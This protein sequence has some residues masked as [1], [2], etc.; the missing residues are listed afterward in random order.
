MPFYTLYQLYERFFS[1][2][3]NYEETDIE[4]PKTFQEAVCDFYESTPVQLSVAVLIALNFV[5]AVIDAQSGAPWAGSVEHTLTVIFAVELCINFVGNAFAP[6]FRSGW[7]WFDMLVVGVS[8]GQIFFPD[9][10]GIA[11]LRLFRAFRAARIFRRLEAQRRIVH[12]VVSSLVG[13]SNVLM[14]IFLVIGIWS[15]LSVNFFGSQFPDEFGSVPK[16]MRT[17]LQIVT[18]DGWMSKIVKPIVFSRA[19]AGEQI[20]AAFLFISFMVIMMLMNS[21]IAVLFDTYVQS[22]S[23]FVSEKQLRQDAR[24]AK[25]EA[26]RA[27]VVPVVDHIAM[28][29]SVPNSPLASSA[30][31]RLV[32]P[33]TDI[34]VDTQDTQW[35]QSCEDQ[36]LRRLNRAEAMLYPELPRSHQWLHELKVEAVLSGSESLRR[37]RELA[38]GKL[39]KQVHVKHL[40]NNKI[41]QYLVALLITANFV[42]SAYTA[43]VVDKAD[44][45]RWERISFNETHPQ[46]ETALLKV[47]EFEDQQTV[48]DSIEVWFTVVFGI[49]LVINLYGNFLLP[50]CSS[51]W[52]WFDFLVVATSI[53]A[54]AVPDMP[55]ITVLRLFRAFRVFR[56]FKRLE[57]LRKVILGVVAAM[58]DVLAAF[59]MII[60]LTGIWS[61]LAVDLLGEQFPAEFGDFFKSVLTWFQVMT[62]DAW[63]SSILRRILDER[64]D[65]WW[66]SVLF[67]T[68]MFLTSIMLLNTMVVVLID[69]YLLATNPS[70]ILVDDAKEAVLAV[71]ESIMKRMDVVEDYMKKKHFPLYE[72]LKQ[73]PHLTVQHRYDCQQAILEG[74][75]TDVKR[76]IHFLQSGELMPREMWIARM[77][78]TEETPHAQADVLA[79]PDDNADLALLNHE[80]QLDHRENGGHELVDDVNAG[81]EQQGML[82]QDG[83]DAE[84]GA[85][86]DASPAPAHTFQGNTAAPVDPSELTKVPENIVG[87]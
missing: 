20:A 19:T 58:K 48:F 70:K 45:R 22:A 10:P 14:L 33:E 56:L 72:R 68:Y 81:A 13:V 47:K 50:F 21:V 27:S 61:V 74:D 82:E 36:I 4:D 35:V 69:K 85:A 8:L 30:D 16:A 3:T 31:A 24:E 79:L 76:I 39:W 49:E 62:F 42:V 59:V 11:S 25:L 29:E 87:W 9:V 67:V 57:S 73:M 65:M 66:V 12:A 43:Q 37:A 83:I 7:N 86:Q 52:N 46:L 60:G 38:Q 71:T 51:L 5:I 15:V 64:P 41:Y 1:H 44:W 6:F 23:T 40:V 55:G 54:I 34:G 2:D 32:S 77:H 80:E 18:F 84:D 78:E 17:F 28:S 26:K 75:E 63:S 53:V